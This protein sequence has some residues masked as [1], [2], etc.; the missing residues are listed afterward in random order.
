LDVRVRAIIVAI[1]IDKI[2][3]GRIGP[4]GKHIGDVITIRNATTRA[5]SLDPTLSMMDLVV[6]MAKAIGQN[7]S[8]KG[9]TVPNP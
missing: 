6:A 2:I 1:M 4:Q 8:N 7:L 3:Q 5:R 9:L